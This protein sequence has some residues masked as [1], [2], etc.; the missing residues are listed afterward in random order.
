VGLSIE[1]LDTLK[2]QGKPYQYQLFPDL[3]HNTAF[4]KSNEPLTAAIHWI[5]DLHRLKKGNK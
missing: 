5:K 2:A 4:A 3:G 1:H